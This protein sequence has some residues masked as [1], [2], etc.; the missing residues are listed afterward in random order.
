[1]LHRAGPDHLDL[2]RLWRHGH[3]NGRVLLISRETP[4]PTTLC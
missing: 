1:M 4:L 3:A 2:L